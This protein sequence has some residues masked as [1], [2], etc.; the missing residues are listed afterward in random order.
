MSDPIRAVECLGSPQTAFGNLWIKING[1]ESW[2]ANPWVWV[3]EFKRVQ[4]AER[5][6]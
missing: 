2:V 4:A 3:V 5:A 6:A 1:Q